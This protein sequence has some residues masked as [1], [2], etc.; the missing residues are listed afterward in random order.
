MLSLRNRLG[1]TAGLISTLALVFALF[2]GS[3]VAADGASTSAKGGGAKA[4]AKKFAKQFSKQFSLR[5]SKR[6]STPGPIGPQGFPGLPGAPGADGSDGSDGQNGQN[7][8]NGEDGE[9]G[10]PGPEGPTGPEGSPWTELGTL[11]SGE[12]LTGSWSTFGEALIP[13]EFN[14]PLAAGLPEENTHPAAPDANCPGTAAD[15]QADP[16][17]LCVYTAGITPAESGEV[18]G[19]HDTSA[20]GFPTGGA[21]TSGA[22]VFYAGSESSAAWGTWAVTAP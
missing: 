11:P 3:A 9:P 18:L 15:P 10:E 20:E 6:F 7:G 22:A 2:A 16:G 4:Q 13:I 14:I 5:F 17:H 19:I 21:A 12:T 1:V 8:E